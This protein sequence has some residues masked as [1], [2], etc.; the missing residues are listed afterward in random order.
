MKE[1][2][3]LLKRKIPFYILHF[4]FYILLIL[5]LVSCGEVTEVQ[6]VSLSGSIALLND[7]GNPDLDP[8]DFSEVTVALYELAYLDTTIVR[9]NNT[10]PQIGVKITQHT[11]F[12]H[13]LQTPLFSTETLADG[14]FEIDKIPTGTYNLVAQKAGYGFRYIYEISIS[15]GDNILADKCK[16]KNV[17]W[18]IVDENDARKDNFK[19]SILNFTLNRT[20]DLTLFPEVHI[21]G[22]I[23][24]H[25]IVPPF[26]HLVI[27]TDTEFAPGT[28]FT[29]SPNAVV[30]INPGCDLTIHGNLTAQA[31]EDNMFWVTSNHVFADDSQFKM[32]NV[33]CNSD[34]EPHSSFSII[35][36]TLNRDSDLQLYNSMELS[37]VAS[38]SDDLIEWGK[39]DHA[40]ICLLNQVN[41][42]HME[43]GVFRNAGSGF[44][45][46]GVD[47]TFCSI[48]NI[49]NISNETYGAIFYDN[50]IAGEIF[51][52][53]ICNT[54][55]GIRVK[56]HSFPKILN[57]KI[58][59]SSYGIFVKFFSH[60]EILH[61]DIENCEIAII[62]EY[63]SY[64]N[65]ELNYINSMEGILLDALPDEI[66]IHNNNIN[67]SQNAIKIVFNPP[68]PP[69]N[70]NAKDN[71]YFTID[72]TKI[73]SIIIDKTDYS[74]ENQQ[75]VGY[76]DYLPFLISSNNEAGI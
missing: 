39:F 2:S 31:E 53:I 7:S 46:S 76:I 17:K 57:N 54:T 18:G 66:E 15:E 35:H 70:I 21:S 68:E 42:L 43:N 64:P 24:H 28:N 59:N 41:N 60:P 19:S 13:R 33:K 50:Q 12:D 34:P 22:I 45:S 72:E 26:H 56:T 38:V 20:S 36:S 27:D 65:I 25:V 74:D 55:R 11:E 51:N 52:N 6:K 73:E 63:D 40:T 3:K 37:P 67:C 14:S 62:S 58:L 71:Y 47:L 10:Y 75:Y 4:T 16:I 61:N 9:I 49:S 8:I 48:S 23:V 32:E 69:V 1:S 30:R 44:Y 5:S 29:I